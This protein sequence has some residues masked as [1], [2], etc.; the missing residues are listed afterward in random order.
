MKIKIN[1]VAQHDIST[2]A[3]YLA[4]NYGQYHKDEENLLPALE[5]EKN[6]QKCRFDGLKPS[7]RFRRTRSTAVSWQAVADLR[8]MTAMS[9]PNWM[10]PR[11][12]D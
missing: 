2:N 1:L 7:L 9:T 4:S 5:Y 3:S 12:G 11:M 6:N 8:T 10:I